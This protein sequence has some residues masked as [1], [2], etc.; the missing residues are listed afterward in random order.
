MSALLLKKDTLLN[1]DVVA[2]IYPVGV[3]IIILINSK[4]FHL[5]Y[6]LGLPVILVKMLNGFS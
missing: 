2:E 3:L 5:R 4:H 6:Q 1:I